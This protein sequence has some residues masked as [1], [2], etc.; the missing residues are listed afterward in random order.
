MKGFTL[1]ENLVAMA[2]LM[3][4]LGGG[5]VAVG[6]FNKG[7]AVF[8]EAIRV[9][10]GLNEQYV[11]AIEGTAF[12]EDTPL[13]FGVCFESDRYYLFATTS[14]W[15]ERNNTYTQMITL[16]ENMEFSDFNF[17]NDCE[18]QSNSCAI[19]F[20][21]TGAL[22]QAGSVVLKDNKTSQEYIIS[23]SKGGLVELT[24]L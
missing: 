17:L 19:F 1:I 11:K 12:G 4:A 13:K 23:V 20:P 22:E 9:K 8:Y 7:K 3:I 10:S 21:I 24:T 16:P 15:S 2:L 5:L 6:Q 14:V 18:G